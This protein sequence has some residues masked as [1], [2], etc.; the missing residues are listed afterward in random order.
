MFTETDQD[1]SQGPVGSCMDNVFPPFQI[2]SIVPSYYRP[3]V[4]KAQF[5][6][7]NKS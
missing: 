4:I 1:G 2:V 6:N 5:S 7:V 3:Q